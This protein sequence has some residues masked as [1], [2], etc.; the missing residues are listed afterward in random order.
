MSA[1]HFLIS[2]TKCENKFYIFYWIT[3]KMS[4]VTIQFPKELIFKN[5]NNGMLLYCVKQ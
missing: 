4:K 2:K 5:L 1:S 3:P